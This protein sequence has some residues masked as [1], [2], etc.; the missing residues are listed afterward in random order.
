MAPVKRSLTI[1]GHRT[2][3]TLEPEFWQAAKQLAQSRSISI[4][5]LVQEIDE[6]RKDD[7]LS[8]AVRVYILQ[9]LQSKQEES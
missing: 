5:S 7:N 1:A 6:A 9:N 2:S 4:A 8:S 3:L